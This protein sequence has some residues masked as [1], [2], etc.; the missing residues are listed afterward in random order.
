ME[1]REFRCPSCSVRFKV[2]FPRGYTE[3]RCIVRCPQCGYKD[4][5]DLIRTTPNVPFDPS[6]RSMEG[7]RPRGR[8]GRYVDPV[9]VEWDAQSRPYTVERDDDDIKVDIKDRKSRSRIPNLLFRATPE[10]EIVKRVG[11]RGDDYPSH[12]DDTRNRWVLPLAVIFL[13]LSCFLGLF[14]TIGSSGHATDTDWQEDDHI[15]NPQTIFGRVTDAD[16][17]GVENAKVQCL[18]TDS[19]DITNSQGWFSLDNITRSPCTI[20]ASRGDLGSSTVKISVEKN[21]PDHINMVIGVDEDRTDGSDGSDHSSIE[22]M[23]GLFVLMIIA[24]LASLLA[25]MLTMLKRWHSIAV[26]CALLGCLSVGYGAGLLMSLAAA[27]MVF[28]QRPRFG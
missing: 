15:S 11:R 8:R 17:S 28:L 24:S 14:Y 2:S 5:V 25:A 27:V 18:G 13:L 23:D 26:P 9:E 19:T 21:L 7:K 22:T 4:V 20:R 16:G 1:P 6:K 12:A 3:N 10:P